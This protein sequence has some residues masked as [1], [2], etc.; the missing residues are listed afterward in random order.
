MSVAFICL[1]LFIFFLFSKSWIKIRWMICLLHPLYPWDSDGKKKKPKKTCVCLL[2]CDFTTRHLYILVCLSS[3][4]TMQNEKQGNLSWFIQS[5]WWWLVQLNHITVMQVTG[6]ENQ[7]H[8]EGNVFNHPKDPRQKIKFIWGEENRN[9]FTCGVIDA[10]LQDIMSSIYTESGPWNNSQKNKFFETEVF[11]EPSDKIKNNNF[12]SFLLTYCI[13]VLIVALIMSVYMRFSREKNRLCR[14]LK[15][16]YHQIWHPWH[17]TVKHWNLDMMFLKSNTTSL[18][19][20][21]IPNVTDKW[22]IDNGLGKV[23]SRSA[24]P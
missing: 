20:M 14:D 8:N 9:S 7:H 10:W 1:T 16:T 24:V 3:K 19:R 17:Y 11:I 21:P 6:S 13:F 18:P 22:F 2:L 12:V 5:S 15:N 4:R 23:S